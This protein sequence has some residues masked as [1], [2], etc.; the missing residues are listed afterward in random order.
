MSEARLSTRGE[1]AATAPPPGTPERLDQ[2][3][4]WRLATPLILGGL[5]QTLFSLTDTWFVGRISS[6]ATAAVAAVYGL[7]FSGMMVL[8]AAALSVQTFAA[9]AHGAGRH[10]AAGR[11]AWSGVAA[12]LLTIPGFVIL[13]LALDLIL[14]ALGI[15][16]EIRRLAGLYWWPRFVVAGPL[17]VATAALCGFFTA[18]EQGR[19]TLV[20]NVAMGLLNI[21]FNDLLV[22]RAGAGVAGSGWGTAAASGCGL[23]IAL[24]LFLDPATRRR[25]RSHL[26]WRRPNLWRPLAFGLP[27]GLGRAAD[28]A[29]FALIQLMAVRLGAAQGAA[30]QIVTLLNTLCYVLT[31]GLSSA[32][33]SLVA[34]ALGAGHP[35]R[36]RAIGDGLVR[37]AAPLLVGL[38]VLIAWAAPFLTGL[39]I[40]SADPLSAQ[41]LKLSA[42]T[43]VLAAAFQVTDGLAIVIGGN[44]RAVGDVR[45]PAVWTTLL[46]WLFWVPLAHALVFAPGAALVVG[47]PQFGLGLAGAW[48]ASIAYGGLLALVLALRWR[49]LALGLANR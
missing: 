28:M 19:R 27:L 37:L 43:L 11:A 46:A 13:G 14:K 45:V 32:G 48:W 8:G 16:P 21:A 2:R 40:S 20:V 31:W 5:V 15:D 49:G 34:Q 17:A 3:R 33:A 30:M 1:D 42:T 29:A 12:T 35:A 25:F 36:A 39:F 4:I 38:G 9:Q 26:T 6:E 7:T 41:T 23:A 44:L 24:W 22:I 47:L 10:V 18:V